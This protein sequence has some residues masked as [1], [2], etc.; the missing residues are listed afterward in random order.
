M[1]SPCF[2]RRLP[3]QASTQTQGIS[4]FTSQLPLGRTP[5]QGP[6]RSCLGQFMG[7]DMPVELSAHWPHIW[8]SN[9]KPLT[10]FSTAATGRSS[11][12]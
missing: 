10:T 11:R 3:S 5:P 6:L 8:Q 4:G 12:E 2:I 1:A 7:Q 9:R